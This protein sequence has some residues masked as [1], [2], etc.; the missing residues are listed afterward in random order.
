MVQNKH[1]DAK[2]ASDLK[3]IELTTD[4]LRGTTENTKKRSPIKK[5]LL[6]LCAFLLVLVLLIGGAG[7]FLYI[8]VGTPTR[9]LIAQGQTIMDTGQALM[10]AIK[11]QNI[12]LT[13]ETL[14][15]LRTE[16]TQAKQTYQELLWLQSA[17]YIGVYIKDGNHA[18]NAAF[19]G[20]DAADKAIAALEPNADL[21]GLKGNSSFT[22]GS[23][24]ERIQIAVKTMT[25]LIPQINAMAEDI[26]VLRKELEQIDPMRYPEEFR[27]IKIRSQL[28][29]AMETIENAANLFVNAQPLLTKLPEIL[30]EPTEKRYLILF[31]ND[32]ELRPTGGFLTAYAQFRFVRGKA[33][34]ERSDDI[35]KLDEARRKRFPAPKEILTYHKGVNEWHIRDSNLSPDLKVSMRQFE[36]MYETVAGKERIDGIITIDT[37]AFVEFLRILGPL[38][39]MGRE[40]SVENDP[41]CD[42]PKAVY[43]LEDYATRP[44]NYIRTDR[45]DIIGVLMQTMMQMALGTSPSKYW[46]QLFQVGLNQIYEKHIMAYFKDPETQKAVEAFNMAG[47]IMTKEETASVL[48]YRE[49][50]GW[51]YLHVNHANMAGQKANMFVRE[52]FTK[53]VTIN[54]DGT[55]TTKLV[56]DYKNPFPGSDCNLERGGLCLNAPLRNWVRV[57]VPKGSALIESKGTISPSSGKPQDMIVYDSLEKTVFEGFLIVNPKGIARLEVTY[58]S[59]VR[60]DRTYNVLIQKQPGTSGQEFELRVN[61]KTRSFILNTDTEVT[62]PL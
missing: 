9:T 27:G 43:E 38:Y 36:E 57:Y 58:T 31:Q 24:D 59:P 46:G 13:K 39:I 42:C 16:L 33:I 11:T 32:K 55:I 44:V 22:A 15:T 14:Q 40:F 34:L 23:A 49:G 56:V 51:D 1:H 54:S 5:I 28:V 60:V 47:R 48:K 20:L 4:V 18:F 17:P 10:D 12:D 19:A 2:S 37:H 30:G 52:S 21:L 53:D 62:V 3:K 6:I 8:R 45:K 26:D 25:A 41:R 7:A 61:G 29:N 50:E 35:Y